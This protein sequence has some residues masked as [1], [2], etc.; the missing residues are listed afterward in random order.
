LSRASFGLLELSN[1]SI[2]ASLGYST[3]DGAYASRLYVSIIP[4]NHVTQDNGQLY[5]PCMVSL[6]GASRLF[7]A[8]S[9][10]FVPAEWKI[11]QREQTYDQGKRISSIIEMLQGIVPP[12]TQL[13][14]IEVFTMRVVGKRHS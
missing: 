4:T 11:P 6:V 14:V 1:D 2:P 13:E 7:S 10:A 3:F 9:A 12:Q 5:C 8:T